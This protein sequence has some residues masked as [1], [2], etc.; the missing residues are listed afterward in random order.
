MS[1]CLNEKNHHLYEWIKK[2]LVDY[3]YS[4]EID[5]DA[6]MIIRVIQTSDPVNYNEILNVSKAHNE[7]VFG[8][9]GIKYIDYVGLLR[10]CYP[11]HATYN[12]TKLLRDMINEN[13]KGL[14]LYLDADT[15]VQDEN[16]DFHAHYSRMRE[17]HQVLWIAQ[18]GPKDDLFIFN[19]GVFSVDLASPLVRKI[20]NIWDDIYGAYYSIED[21]QEASSWDDIVNDQTALSLIFKAFYEK[22]PQSFTSHILFGCFQSHWKLGWSI[23]D[24]VDN[25]FFSALRAD[26][27]GISGEEEMLKRIE[28]IT[29]KLEILNAL[30]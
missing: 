18:D 27:Y 21:Y 26:A 25:I 4:A 3:A 30:S 22:I 13:Y 24:N 7:K 19:A 16:Y 17:N 10:G 20:I 11:H 23:A 15:I 14:V 2:Q 8:R 5:E 1:Q 9:I 29:K 28:A 6:E 12:R